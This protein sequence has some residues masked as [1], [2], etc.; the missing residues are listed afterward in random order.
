MADGDDARLRLGTP[1]NTICL[2]MMRLDHRCWM[3]KRLLAEEKRQLLSRIVVD[4]CVQRWVRGG[5]EARR[6]QTD[7]NG[8]ASISFSPSYLAFMASTKASKMSHS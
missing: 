3:E 6:G 7:G 8:R 1:N 4:F 5:D 2:L